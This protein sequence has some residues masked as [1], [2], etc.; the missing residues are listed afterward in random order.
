M[1]HNRRRTTKKFRE[2]HPREVGKFYRISDKNGG[3]PARIYDSNVNNDT[4]L[5][6]RFSTKPRE[7]RKKLKHSIDPNEKNN[8]SWLVKRPDAVGYDDMTYEERYK[9]YR[10]HK[11][12]MK[13][14]K[15]YQKENKKNR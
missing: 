14:I 8:T 5:I 2:K 9:D 1:S 4:Y 15:R 3:H 11:E 13:T 6:Q 7:D 10:V 12:D